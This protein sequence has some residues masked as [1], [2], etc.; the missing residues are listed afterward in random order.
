MSLRIDK[1]APW[2][3]RLCIDRPDKRNAIDHDV[4][5]A[6]MDA[7]SDA[8]ADR[9]CRA[10]VLGGVGGMFSAGGDIGS[11]SELSEAQA[12][13]RMQHIHRLCRQLQALPL[14]VVSAA[15]GFCAGAGVGLALLGDVIV[16]GSGSKFLFPF[17]KLG[18]VP[19]WGSLRS[20]PARVG[21]GAARRM[22][23]HGRV[24]P[25]EEAASL[26][27]VDDFVGDGDV[28]AHA[29]TRAAELAQLP[30]AAFALQK[31]RLNQPSANFDEELQRE[32]DDQAVLLLGADFKEG[33]RA[34]A[35][36][37]A[38]DFVGAGKEANP[39]NGGAP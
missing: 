31:R 30:Q 7:L 27:L 15:E 28:M 32:E 19:D 21:V 35:E 17:F 33:F 2:V 1:P 13:Q 23:L 12:R 16:A 5:Q 26:G 11:M 39:D 4:R 9:E 36:K 8:Q 34:F 38:P 37:R 10:I 24:I 18:L 29:I 25:G 22:L 6:L 3:L 20:L 14:P